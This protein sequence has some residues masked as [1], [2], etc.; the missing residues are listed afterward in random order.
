MMQYSREVGWSAYWM[1]HSPTIPR[2][3]TVLMA[4]SRSMWYSSL[5]RVWDGAMTME[6]PVCVPR[7]SKFSM[8]HTV[9]QLSS[10]SRTTSY[11]TS[12]HPSIDLSTRIWGLNENALPPMS[13]SCASSLQMPD[14][15]PPRAKADR[16]ISGY[17][18]WCAASTASARVSQATE[19]AIFS[20]ISC[21]LSENICRSSVAMI[22]STEVPRTLT[23]YFSKMPVASSSTPQFSA[24]CPPMEMMIPS[25]FSRL[26]TSSTKSGVTGRKKTASAPADP[27]VPSAP[28]FVWT[29]AMLGFMRTTSLPSSFSALIA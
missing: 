19:G 13:R 15:S 14:P 5:L 12:F 3:R 21:S 17:P 11:S 4:V 22:V 16:I 1:L 25:G 18:M 9:T 27:P 7:G 29:E 24:V 10:A 20:S 6:S 8:L 2:C 28:T 23:P 26:M